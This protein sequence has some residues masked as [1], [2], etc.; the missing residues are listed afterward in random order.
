MHAKMFAVGQVHRFEIR[1]GAENR[2]SLGVDNAQLQIDFGVEFRV[3]GPGVGGVVLA[4]NV[5]VAHNAADMVR[6]LQRAVDVDR[7]GIGYRLQVL[8]RARDG[9]LTRILLEK[10][11][12]A[13]DGCHQQKGEKAFGKRSK[14]DV[15]SG[16]R[17]GA[18]FGRKSRYLFLWRG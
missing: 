13:N 15:F 11:V 7:Q 12:A 14:R 16:L 3:D 5:M 18:V 10:K 17:Q 9:L 8:L 2:H 1:E 4:L 6:L